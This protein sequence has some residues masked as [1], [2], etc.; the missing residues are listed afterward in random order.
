MN[1]RNVLYVN[2]HPDFAQVA[3][4]TDDEA[5]QYIDKIQEHINPYHKFHVKICYNK[6]DVRLLITSGPAWYKPSRYKPL[7]KHVFEPGT[8]L[9]DLLDWA[10]L[11]LLF[12]TTP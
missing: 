8:P 10:H 1:Y 5:E 9:S 3:Y 11:T 7:L 12:G 4:V 6:T 2:G